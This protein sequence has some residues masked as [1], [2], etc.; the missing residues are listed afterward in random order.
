MAFQSHYILYTVCAYVRW[1]YWKKADLNVIFPQKLLNV[2]ILIWILFFRLQNTPVVSYAEVVLSKKGK[3][4]RDI[5]MMEN[6]RPEVYTEEHEKMLGD[7]KTEWTLFVDGYG[8]D[9]K[10]I[11]DPVRGKTCHQCR[12]PIEV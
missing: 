8:K 7:T 1:A 12:Y 9:G 5:L 2:L 3:D 11:Y 10:K 6:T 4:G